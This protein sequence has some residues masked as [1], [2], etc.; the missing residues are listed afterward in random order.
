[1]GW[2][3]LVCGSISPAGKQNAASK[4]KETGSRFYE[5]GGR[6]KRNEETRNGK[7]KRE[8]P[9]KKA[10]KKKKKEQKPC[11]EC[12]HRS[13]CLLNANQALYHLS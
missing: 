11:G 3:E 8:T 12:G 6:F 2:G 9:P 5:G 13:R 10:Q 4:R 7:E 1:M